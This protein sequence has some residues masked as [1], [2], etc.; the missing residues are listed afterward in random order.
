LRLFEAMLRLRRFEEKAGVLYA[1]G[2]LEHPLPL[3]IGCEAAYVAVMAA[4]RSGDVLAVS[5][6]GSIAE[7][8][9]G[10]GFLDAF[11]G[12]TSEDSCSSSIPALSRWRIFKDRPVSAGSC[13]THTFQQA[14]ALLAPGGVLC[15]IF[16]S[17]SDAQQNLA[18]LEATSAAL[19]GRVVA[20]VIVCDGKS[21]ASGGDDL[22]WPG[23]LWRSV[24]AD[25]SDMEATA[26]AMALARASLVPGTQNPIIFIA[27]PVFMGHARRQGNQQRLEPQRPDPIARLRQRLTDEVQVS[28]TELNA[29][30]A[31]V[32][33]QIA[34]AV[35]AAGL[36]PR[37]KD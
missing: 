31:S 5:E 3:K 8:A 23:A 14:N 35:Q 21:E 36:E 15:V 11:G 13:A 25:G 16:S 9:A 18:A 26:A 24:H 37:H 6:A 17:L 27:T 20:V 10:A 29:L 1:L 22:S 19:A 33:M 32:K 2:A 4:K 12:L 34:Q 7:L 30:D 28:D